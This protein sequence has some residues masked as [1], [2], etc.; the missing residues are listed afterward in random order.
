MMLPTL[1]PPPYDAR[2]QALVLLEDLVVIVLGPPDIRHK[3]SKPPQSVDFTVK[4]CGPTVR[5]ALILH[6]LEIIVTV[7]LVR[8]T[9]LVV[10]C[11]LVLRCLNP[12]A[13]PNEVLC[14][15]AWIAKE[16]GAGRHPDELLNGQRVPRHA[17]HG[18][19]V[20][21]TKQFR[22]CARVWRGDRGS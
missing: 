1:T 15:D 3:T 8:D 10:T 21:L 11:D 18:A 13:R 20:D 16:A 2:I 14:F 22:M 5:M 19:V 4:S 9:H 7:F 12:S 6:F 17:R